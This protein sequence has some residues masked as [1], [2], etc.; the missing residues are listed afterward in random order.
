VTMDCW[1][2]SCRSAASVRKGSKVEIL[3]KVLL[4]R[5]VLHPHY[6]LEETIASVCA[7]K[8]MCLEITA[9]EWVCSDKAT[10]AADAQL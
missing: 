6:T 3:K 10:N 7:A 4:L 8:L 9:F 1:I 2:I 5:S